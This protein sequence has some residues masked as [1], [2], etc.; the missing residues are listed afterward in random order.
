MFVHCQMS[1]ELLYF[2]FSHFIGMALV[3]IKDV[4]FNPKKVG[5]FSFIAVVLGAQQILHLLKQLRRLLGIPQK[6]RA[7]RRRQGL[8]SGWKG[9]VD[10]IVIVHDNSPQLGRLRLRY[11]Q[12]K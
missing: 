3:V 10:Q 1:E 9:K 7:F 8:V 2:P 11:I 12:P 6:H 4:S 5:F